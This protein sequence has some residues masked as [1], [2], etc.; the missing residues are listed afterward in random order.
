LYDST[1]TE[2]QT[3]KNH[4]LDKIRFTEPPIV[5]VGGSA[6][7]DVVVLSTTQLQ[8][9]APAHAEGSVDVTVTPTGSEPVTITG[10]Y[11][12]V[13]ADAMTVTGVTPNVGPSFGGTW[14]KVS[15]NN[16]DVSSI[17]VND[18]PCVIQE[19]Y[20]ADTYVKCIL[21]SVDISETTFADVVVT[22]SNQNEYTLKDAFEYVKVSKDDDA[23]EARIE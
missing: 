14:I 13:N 2:E 8:C 17:T 3:A 4:T 16:L 12:Y 7:K 15:G 21:P 22:D 19:D 1:L 6:C 9:T 11:E 18:E 10:G 5:T 20:V 23:F